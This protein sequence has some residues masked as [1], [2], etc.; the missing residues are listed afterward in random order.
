M[1]ENLTDGE[2][3]GDKPLEHIELERAQS[4]EPN[5][6]DIQ[7]P[8][9][10]G[11]K[12]LR[13]LAGR[14]FARAE[15]SANMARGEDVTDDERRR[16]LLQDAVDCR[17]VGTRYELTAAMVEAGQVS[18]LTAIASRQGSNAAGLAAQLQAG[19]MVGADPRVAE[20]EKRNAELVTE[21]TKESAARAKAEKDAEGAHAHR[22][23]WQDAIHALTDR[24]LG[25]EAPKE[26]G[27]EWCLEQIRKRFAELEVLAEVNEPLEDPPNSTEWVEA[28]SHVDDIV[29]G[30]KDT[31]G[32]PSSLRG[33][34]DSMVDAGAAEFDAWRRYTETRR[35]RWEENARLEGIDA[36]MAGVLEALDLAEVQPINDANA[37]GLIHSLRSEVRS[38][39]NRRIPRVDGE[40]IA[41]KV[42]VTNDRHDGR[43]VTDGKFEDGAPAWPSAS[44][45]NTDPAEGTASIKPGHTG[46]EGCRCIACRLSEVGTPGARGGVSVPI[47]RFLEVVQ[48]EDEIPEDVIAGAKKELEEARKA[49][50]EPRTVEI[51]QIPADPLAMLLAGAMAAQRRGP[52]GVVKP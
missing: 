49:G 46:S 17:E 48:D 16:I 28:C 31:V 12:R 4:Q 32:F 38:M 39:R 2:G 25:K 13:A 40:P 19:G 22:R 5:A 47:E 1:T 27:P 35:R 20:L 7:K 21:L 26:M 8:D 11:A 41:E 23:R 34:I 18:Q 29:R 51:M 43:T 6:G 36:F 9:L 24:A 44:A 10:T 42:D 15:V 50:R 52:Q 37:R 45:P 30:A 33:A 3:P 14:F